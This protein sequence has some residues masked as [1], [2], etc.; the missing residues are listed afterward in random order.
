MLSGY[1]LILYVASTDVESVDRAATQPLQ[2]CAGQFLAV[3][4]V[5]IVQFASD[6]MWTQMIHP[7]SAQNYL[8]D[9]IKT[10]E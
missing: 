2:T 8:A 4:Q 9:Q 3:T 5:E 1:Y 7:A 10:L 6:K